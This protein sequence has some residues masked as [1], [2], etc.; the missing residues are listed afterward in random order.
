MKTVKE[1]KV[2]I[3]ELGMKVPLKAKKEDLL[4]L[5]NNKNEIKNRMIGLPIKQKY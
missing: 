3:L 4:N 2:E 1:L 5:L